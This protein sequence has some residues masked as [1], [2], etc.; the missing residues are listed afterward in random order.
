MIK[1]YIRL[2]R[3][4]AYRE[5]FVGNTQHSTAAYIAVR[6]RMRAAN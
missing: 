4:R 1:L 6:E 5:E 3:K 2:L